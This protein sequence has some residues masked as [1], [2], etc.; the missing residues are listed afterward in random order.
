MTGEWPVALSGVTESIVATRGPEG[1]WNLAALGLRTGDHTA[2]GADG[3]VT[4]RTWGRTRTR[5]NFERRGSGVVQF[6]RDPLAF[7]DAAL[8]IVE[9]ETPV[10]DDVDAWVEVS[11]ER[12]GSGAEGDTEWIDWALEPER[13]AVEDGGVRTIRR[14][15]NAVIE[16]TVWAS[17]LGVAGYDDAES[18]ERLA[19]LESVVATAGDDRDRR[20]FDRIAD[21]VDWQRD[22]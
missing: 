4:A 12:I 1:N 5:I 10:L 15:F 7:V 16:A 18:R 2:G 19:F 6:P 14:G 11:V 22:T 9:R 21:H 8:G 20:A 17:R 3:R 13:V